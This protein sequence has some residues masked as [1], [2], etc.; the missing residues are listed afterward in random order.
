VNLVCCGLLTLLVMHRPA[1]TRLLI[2]LG[3]SGIAMLAHAGDTVLRH[4]RDKLVSEVLGRS[5]RT[6]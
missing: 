6:R 2:G 5:R 3:A 1:E 4:H